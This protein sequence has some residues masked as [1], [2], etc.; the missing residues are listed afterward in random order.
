MSISGGNIGTQI[1]GARLT[2]TIQGDKDY[3]KYTKL[4]VWI[5]KERYCNNKKCGEYDLP[6]NPNINFC[7]TCGEENGTRNADI[8]LSVSSEKFP[9]RNRE[10]DEPGNYPEAPYE[11]KESRISIKQLV[12][13]LKEYE[14][15]VFL[16]D[17]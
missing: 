6:R 16:D 17:I 1:Q 2:G 11:E 5:P 7:P 3:E 15:D 4:G 14:N 10:K 13:L 8:Y 9:N 12:R